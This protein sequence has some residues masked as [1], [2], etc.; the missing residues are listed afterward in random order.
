ML[1]SADAIQ[2]C[3]E[4]GSGII[5]SAAEPTA[6]LVQDPVEVDRNRGGSSAGTVRQIA[7]PGMTCCDVGHGRGYYMRCHVN[8]RVDQIPR[9]ER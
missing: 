1:I 6:L 7:E 9:S 2:T 4:L 8:A 5:A 3:W